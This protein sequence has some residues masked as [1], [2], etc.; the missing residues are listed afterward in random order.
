MIIM[1]S[2]CHNDALA[3]NSVKDEYSSCGV[4]TVCRKCESEI[5]QFE[6]KLIRINQK[7]VGINRVSK[8]DLVKTK[9]FC[10]RHGLEMEVTESEIKNNPGF[11]LALYSSVILIITWFIT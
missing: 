6:N 10:M 8:Q 4:T 9:I 1:C 11:K 5:S 3:I 2:L 7:R